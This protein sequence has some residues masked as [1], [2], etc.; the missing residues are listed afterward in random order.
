MAPSRPQIRAFLSS[1]FSDFLE[2]RSLLVK[3]V[4]PELRSKAKD[5]G[6][7]LVEVDLRWGITEEQSKQG[8]TIGICL[9]EIERCRPYFIGLLGDRYGWVPEH[10]DY[11]PELLRRQNWLPP[12]QGNASVTELEIL[13]GV[14][15]NPEMAG[16]V[17]FYFRDPAY[18][19][20]K[21]AEGPGWRSES[22]EE[23]QKLEALKERIRASGFPVV[24]KGVAT[25]KAI[26]DRIE[27]DLWSLIEEQFPEVPKTDPLEL[28]A[29]RHASY[30]ADRTGL[31]LGGET[32]IQQL[33]R[34]IS[35][36]EQRIL[37]TGESGAG[38]SALI[39]N[40]V[41]AHESSQPDDV[42][43]CHHLGS[44]NDASALRPLLARMIDSASRLLVEAEELSEPLKV[45]QDWWELVT[46]VTNTLSRLSV[47]AIRQQ[48]RWIWVLDGLDKLDLDDQQALPWLPLVLPEG[49][50]LVASALDCQVRTLL[51]ERQFTELTI[52]PLG[53]AER[54]QL[55]Q[56]YLSLY[57]KE[58]VPA[59]RQKITRHRQGSS[60]LF[61]RVLLEELRLCGKFETLAEQLQAYLT[62][63]SVAD[64]YELVLQRLED[65]GHGDAVQKVMAALWA[66]RAGLSENELLAITGLVH[67]QWAPIGIGLQEAL[68]EANGRLVFG[69]D[70]LRQA[71]K[72]RYLATDEMERDAH[73]TIA[74]YFESRD[75]WDIRDSEE[76]PWQLIRA[77]RI[78]ELRDWLVDPT[79]LES[80]AEDLETREVINFWSAANCDHEEELD[81]AIMEAV[82]QEIEKRREDP[83]DLIWFVDQIAELL[84]EAGLYREPLLRL[85]KLS[86]EIEEASDGR[87]DEFRLCSLE[88]LADAQRSLGNYDAALEHYQRCLEAS[89]KLRGLEHERTLE[90]VALLAV[91][92]RSK[93]EYDKAEALYKRCLEIRERL[94]GSEHPDTL[95]IIN[96][97]AVLYRNI[98]DYSRAEA[99]YLQVLNA[100]R[101]LLGDKNT[102]FLITAFNVARLYFDLG[103]FAKAE[104]YSKISHEGHIGHYGVDHPV[105]LNSALQMMMISVER[106]DV[107]GLEARCESILEKCRKILGPEHVYTSRAL[108]VLAYI[109][110]R[111]GKYEMAQEVN[112][113]SLLV[114]EKTLG[115]ENPDT[116]TAV[117]NLAASFLDNGNYKQAEIH[118]RRDF[119]SLERIQGPEHPN[120]NSTR[121]D[122]ARCLSAL[123]RYDEAIP[124]RRLELEI[125]AK[126]DGRTAAGTLSSISGLAGDLE[127]NGD[128]EAA[129][130]LYRECLDGRIETLGDKHPSTMASRYDLACCLSRLERYDE[131][132]D[133]RR[134]EL[135]W[136]QGEEEVDP[137]SMLISMLGLGRD[138]LAAEQPEEALD[139]LQ[140]CLSQRQELLGSSHDGTIVTDPSLLEAF[141]GLALALIQLDRPAEAEP[142]YRRC[143]SGFEASRGPEHPYTMEMVFGLAETLTA[144]ERFREAIPLRRREIAWCREQNGDTD[145]GTFSSINNLA[146]D[147]RKIGELEEAEALFRELVAGRQQ[148][149]VPEDFDIGRALGGLAKTLE[150]A[151]KLEEALKAYKQALD[152][153][154]EYR[155]PD[156][157]HTNRKRLDLAR[158]LHKLGDLEEARRQLDQLEGSIGSIPDPDDDDQS[159]LADAAALR[160]LLNP[161]S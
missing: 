51:Q 148:V 131:A 102:S 117:R 124:L 97:L 112:L 129:Q 11:R 65:D 50:H 110:K 74:D 59:L 139:V 49:V 61:L 17:F 98:G 80:L 126:R 159:L 32:Y 34:W 28:E 40:W 73:S 5:R 9:D 3:E 58:L 57:T 45:P 69:H 140:D 13:H 83:E 39:S 29:A 116:L 111:T 108:S 136:C 82:E 143:L 43:F 92:C 6:V 16:R 125:A 37:I 146:I 70:F 42:I 68:S 100:Q 109:Y 93:G 127:A 105:T 8:Q 48:R 156:D 153:H 152:H 52:G 71:V 95:S 106:G 113:E 26:A 47:W 90:V 23:R 25:P 142:L 85:R 154:L 62:A 76:L 1:T 155:G 135:S 144:L 41:A 104:I 53:E 99:R 20:A 157:W 88:S 44:S 150:I 145:R 134:I 138:L 101:L 147:L 2:E 123:E 149:L 27:A 87:G 18:S 89:E 91:T 151:G 64:L 21:A 119:E 81:E 54:E 33:Q 77:N 115:L 128:I 132:I 66:S 14:L 121:Y 67:A 137:E 133:L 46:Q 96:N 78:Q 30:R 122:L 4:F 56:K 114:C 86:L 55:I 19:D 160:E 12:H 24:E 22:P 103:D 75:E 63:E 130:P 161:P 120:T 15:N 36:G 118:Y 10:G 79:A 35:A 38:K 107:E 84:D 94:L 141:S 31:Y 60:P 72:A 158:L 7:E